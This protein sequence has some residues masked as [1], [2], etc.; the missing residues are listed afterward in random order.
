MIDGVRE[1]MKPHVW[2]YASS[3]HILV[4]Q[5]KKGEIRLSRHCLVIRRSC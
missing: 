3:R 2:S 1:R 5:N 4:T